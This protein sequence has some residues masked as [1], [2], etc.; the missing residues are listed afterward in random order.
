ML[1]TS[2][3][4]IANVLASA[5]LFQICAF[6]YWRHNHDDKVNY[7]IHWLL[8][9]IQ[10][11]FPPV[12]FNASYKTVLLLNTFFLK[13]CTYTFIHANQRIICK[14]SFFLYLLQF[15]VLESMFKI[16]HKCYTLTY[17]HSKTIIIKIFT[18][19]RG[20]SLKNIFCFV[21]SILRLSS[22]QQSETKHNLTISGL[23]H[24]YR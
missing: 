21:S 18:H 6:T 9:S 23:Y 13:F 10:H 4:I 20:I 15:Y 2:T 14:C 22:I 3:N 19:N 1:G 12:D 7:L 11:T 8:N 5:I 24:V 16:L 17:T